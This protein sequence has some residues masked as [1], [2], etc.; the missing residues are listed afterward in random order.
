MS[1]EHN[2]DNLFLVLKGKVNTD[3][4]GVVRWRYLDEHDNP[5]YMTRKEYD[6]YFDYWV[7]S[8]KT[9]RHYTGC[10]LS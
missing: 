2:F 6:N 8:L 4:L 7:E 10:L 5:M 3:Y 9:T 1:H